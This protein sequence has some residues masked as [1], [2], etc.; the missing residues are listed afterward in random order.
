MDTLNYRIRRIDAKGVITTVAGDGIPFVSGM[1]SG[2]AATAISLGYTGGLAVDAAGNVYFSEP[3]QYRI[4]RVTTAGMTEVYASSLDSP[5]SLAVDGAGD[6]FFVDYG[7]VIRRVSASGAITVFASPQTAEELIAVR[8]IA[9]DHSGSVYAAL[10][11]QLVRYSP[12]GGSSVIAGSATV[13]ST[14]YVAVDSQGNVGFVDVQHRSP[15]STLY[16]IREVTAQSAPKTLA[17]ANPKPAADGTPLRDAWLLG[18]SSIAFDQSGNLYLAESQACLIRKIDVGGTLSTFAGTGV[19]GSSAPSGNATA[20]NLAYPV[21]I[22]VDPQSRVWVVDDSWNLYSISQDGTIS[23]FLSLPPLTSQLAIDAKGRLYVVSLGSLLRVLPDRSMQ[24]IVGRGFGLPQVSNLGT[25]PSGN[26]YFTSGLGVYR[27]ND[28]ATYTQ[29]T[30]GLYDETAVAV[31]AAGS[32]WLGLGS[33]IT[34]SNASGAAT[35]GNSSPGFAGDGGLAQNASFSI[36]SLGGAI[37]F[38]PT[39]ELY[40]IDNDRIRKLTGSGPA[41][42]AVIS[43]NGIV[44]AASYIGGAISPGELISIFG[45]NFGGGSQGLIV[46]APQNNSL[47]LAL[48]RTKVLFNG[49]PGA[50]TALTTNQINVFVPPGLLNLASPPQVAVQV[51]DLVSVPVSVPIVATAPGLFSADAS[52][53]GQG[54]ILNQDGSI[55]SS[56]HPAAR[57]TIVS[58]F[59]TGE[60]AESPQLPAGALVLSTPLPAPVNSVTAT[61]GGQPAEVLYAGAAPLLPTGVFQINLRIP[62][63]VSTGSI[64]VSISTGAAATTKQVT[65]SIQ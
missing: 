7:A 49:T 34:I 27:I 44:N 65:I 9:A 45:A 2:G 11:N 40:I 41:D 12:D 56:A 60:G 55:N 17:G 43:S 19:C 31:D 5:G 29:L 6:L 61:V 53:S 24:T 25:D 51:D 26:V 62:Q 10:G 63:G 37:A 47:P 16:E 18:P 33:G 21:S 22:A 30:A 54:A 39:G 57:G 64:P 46:N 59:G 48:G 58:L 20:A 1:D 14:S 28:D 42:A 32:L 36:S 50:I 23:A 15:D 35:L 4:R 8:S 13:V 52:G 38:A 3:D